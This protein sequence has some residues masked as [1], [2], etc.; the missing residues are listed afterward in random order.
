MHSEKKLEYFY[1]KIFVELNGAKP[2][3]A[4]VVP[5]LFH[6]THY[7]EMSE[8]CNGKQAV[9]KGNKKQ[10]S[11]DN[12]HKASQLV[13]HTDN[14]KRQMYNSNSSKDDCLPGNLVW[15]GT[16]RGKGGIFGP[17]QFEFNY[18]RVLQA[19]Q[20]S[21]GVDHMICYRVGGTLVYQNEICHVVI[22]CC[23]NDD[24]YK[25]F[26]VIEEDKSITKFYMLS[27]NSNLPRI[28]INEYPGS[29]RGRDEHV[30]LVFYLPDDNISLEVAN[31]VGYSELTWVPHNR[32]VKSKS[33]CEFAVSPS[34]IDKEIDAKWKQFRLK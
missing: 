10:W 29:D 19:Y 20:V 24:C 26:P 14:S 3:S 13:D 33:S 4:F 5:T 32:C 17:C 21:R 18:R 22:V 1:P 7:K 27:S 25:T 9:F 11:T 12:P 6:S 30:V 8:I 31:E 23:A 28:Q 15:F 2:G 34:V 16:S